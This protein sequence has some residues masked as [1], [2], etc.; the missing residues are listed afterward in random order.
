M[1]H[2]DLSIKIEDSSIEDKVWLYAYH[3]MID[4]MING[5]EV[6]ANEICNKV[7]NMLMEKAEEDSQSNTLKKVGQTVIEANVQNKLELIK[8]HAEN[9]LANQDMENERFNRWL[10]C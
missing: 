4:T 3:Y 9:V 2:A 1:W 7:W 10:A 8:L 6:D 5:K